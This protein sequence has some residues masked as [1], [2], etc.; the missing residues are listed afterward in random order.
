MFVN[1]IFAQVQP[2]P[3]SCV[4]H[5][6][7]GVWVEIA[8]LRFHYSI[9]FQWGCLHVEE[10]FLHFRKDQEP[11]IGTRIVDRDILPQHENPNNSD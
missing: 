11:D 4:Y 10:L 6:D 5:S 1:I 9:S 7:Q 8:F 3:N 2:A